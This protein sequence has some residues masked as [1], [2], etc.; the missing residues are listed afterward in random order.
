MYIAHASVPR[1]I[2]TMTTKLTTQEQ[3]LVAKREKKM[4]LQQAMECFK[5]AFDIVRTATTRRELM[6][7]I[8][9]LKAAISMRPSVGRYALHRFRCGFKSFIRGAVSDPRS[10]GCYS[11]LGC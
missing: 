10:R 8:E 9:L 11:V 5:A 1:P 2:A 7:G 6:E 4:K 3:S